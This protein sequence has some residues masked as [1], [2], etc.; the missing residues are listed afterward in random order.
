MKQFV[1]ILVGL[2]VFVGIIIFFGSFT[3]VRT[4]DIGI[5]YRLGKITRTLE[6][7][8]HLK[9]PFIDSVS[10]VDTLSQ[11]EQV[12]ATA[13]SKDLQNV[14]AT[15][16]VEFGVDPLKV[17]QLYQEIGKDYKAKVIDPAVQEAVKGATAKY[18][19]EEL[20]T[21]RELVREDIKTSLS[22]RLMS[23][24]INL[25][26]VSIVNFD[27]SPSFNQA[28]ENKVTAEQNALTAKNKLEEVKYLAEQKIASAK[29]EAESIRLQSDAANNEKYVAL[30][31]LEVELEQAKRWNG[32]LPVNVYGSAPIPFLNL[33]K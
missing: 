22:A 28:I 21:K 2:A 6:P 33:S 20:V 12:P 14:N 10:K 11:K 25:K 18:T 8:F 16:A 23:A 5:V 9:A 3:I 17:T 32:V 27:F 30:K 24:Y 1:G 31:R 4:G 29:A 26:Q 7:G 13:A 15:V 19:A